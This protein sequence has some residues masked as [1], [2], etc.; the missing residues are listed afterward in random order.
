MRIFPAI[1]LSAALTLAPAAAQDQPL[2]SP[3]EAGVVFTRAVQLVESTMITLPG[4]ARAAEPVLEDCRQAQ[5]NSAAANHRNAGH[6]YSFLSSLRSYLALAESLPRPYPFPEQAAA[7]FSEL[8][9]VAARL[10]AHFRAQLESLEARLRAPDRDNLRRYAEANQ[11]VGPR[12]E[13]QKRVVFL[14]DSITDGW[15]LN[16]Y[17]PDNDFINRGISGQITGE[18][19]GR[20]KADVI[21][22]KPDAVLI[23][24]GTN[25]IARGVAPEVIQNNLTMIAE[26]AKLHGIKV[27]LASIL[28]V[29]DYNKDQNPSYERT[30]GRPIKTI[31]ELNEWIRSYCQKNGHTYL[32][33]YAALADADGF[34]RR[35]LADDGLH[36]NGAGYRVMAPLAWEAIT[37]ATQPAGRRR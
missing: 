32:D 37:Q 34:L 36:P 23:L 11:K 7:Q 18:M 13:G 10:D 12:R 14:G 9:G 29:H 30:P 17:Y 4:L 16:E 6:T 33:Y 27:I 26:L 22:L 19:L 28:P 25:D 15:R 8:R 20:M 21:D 2:L 3:K 35:E 5:A 31:L 1:I 24:A